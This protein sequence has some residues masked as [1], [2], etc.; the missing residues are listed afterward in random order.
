MNFLNYQCGKG[1]QDFGRGTEGQDCR[2]HQEVPDHGR[3]EGDVARQIPIGKDW[4]MVLC[5]WGKLFYLQ[6]DLFCLQLSFL[7]Y[8]PLGPY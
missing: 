7:A 5:S 3:I 6:L 4:H 2:W 8:S 1:L